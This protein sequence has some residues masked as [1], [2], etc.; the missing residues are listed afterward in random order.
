MNE[1]LFSWTFLD[2]FC[3]DFSTD[4]RFIW[5][6]NTTYKIHSLDVPL[7]HH[8]VKSKTNIEKRQKLRMIIINQLLLNCLPP[9]DSCWIENWF[10]FAILMIFLS[11]LILLNF[12]WMV[13]LAMSTFEFL[14]KFL[15]FWPPWH[16]WVCVRSD[17]KWI[18]AIPP[19]V[20]W[21]ASL[22]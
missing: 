21:W 19:T 13:N 3:H 2:H 1:P 10:I 7:T 8:W 6:R 4:Q 12:G 9:E 14:T 11:F 20:I 22:I 16:P 15:V 5:K 17:L 18:W